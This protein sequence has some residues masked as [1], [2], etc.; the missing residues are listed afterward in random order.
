M[1]ISVTGPE[2]S[3]TTNGKHLVC[4]Q[5]LRAL[6]GKRLVYRGVFDNRRV[7]VKLFLQRRHARR[8]WKREVTG[9]EALS[10]HNISLPEI[11]F[12]GELQFHSTPEHETTI[13]PGRVVPGVVL[14]Y[15][16]DAIDL[17]SYWHGGAA[18]KEKINWLRTALITIA[19]QHSKGVI[20]Q[21]LHLG[22]FLVSRG[23]LYTID[24]DGIRTHRS[25]LTPR[26]SWHWVGVFFA[27]V[28]PRFDSLMEVLLPEY[29][30]ARGFNYS[31][32]E[33]SLV[34]VARD[35]QRSKIGHSVV[36]KIFRNSGLCTVDSHFS[37][38]IGCTRR[39]DSPEL[40]RLLGELAKGQEPVGIQRSGG[41]LQIGAAQLKI[42]KFIGYDHLSWHRSSI[43]GASSAWQ[44]AHLT[45]QFGGHTAQPVAIV[46]RKFGPIQWRGYYLSM[47]D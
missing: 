41:L 38:F 42:E 9:L 16:P 39:F 18:E 12:S 32:H 2:L 13:E 43:K 3:L 15:L 7:I 20:Q 24:G 33:L 44:H 34:V 29:C 5:L 26:Q 17:R 4:D 40:K 1:P 45:E 21:D 10:K 11:L 8:H 25:G 30:A 36:S 6:P 31:P 37:W 28:Y 19:E 47:A 46:Q 14:A 27:Q 35:R 23:N 22:N